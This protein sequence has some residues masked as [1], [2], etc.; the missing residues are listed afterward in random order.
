MLL[1]AGIIS[2]RELY[3]FSYLL[4]SPISLTDIFRTAKEGTEIQF[5]GIDLLTVDLKS[6]MVSNAET[7]SDRMNYYAAV[8][9]DPFVK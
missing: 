2:K 5:S 8:G 4:S 6:G 1:L 7:S 3:L 9:I